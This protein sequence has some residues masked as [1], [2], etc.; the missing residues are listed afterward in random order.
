MLVD[1]MIVK[2]LSRLE[3]GLCIGLKAVWRM[4][5]SKTG[6]D[7]H[8]YTMPEWIEDRA[9]GGSKHVPQQNLQ[10]GMCSV[11]S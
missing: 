5:L 3:G 9:Q 7:G 1:V 10:Q 6:N 11:N 2:G 4:S 8:G